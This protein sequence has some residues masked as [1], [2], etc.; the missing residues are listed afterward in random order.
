MLSAVVANAGR[1]TSATTASAK[2]LAP[3]GRCAPDGFQHHAQREDR[4][5]VL[6]ARREVSRLALWPN[7][8]E[9]RQMAQPRPA[10]TLNFSASASGSNPPF[11]LRKLSR[12][13]LCENCSSRERLR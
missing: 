11:A 1:A 4:D 9:R 3:R 7:G 6:L 5:A 2:I 8:A 12:S 10:K 13:L